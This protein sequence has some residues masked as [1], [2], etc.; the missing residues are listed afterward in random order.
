MKGD[1][2]VTGMTR[3]DFT[4]YISK[5]SAIVTDAGGVLSHA[6]IIARELKKPCIIGTRNATKMIRDNDYIEVDANRG[7]VSKVSLK[8]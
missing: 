1:I 4:Q 2:L 8:K 6:A 3:P 7:I 5:A